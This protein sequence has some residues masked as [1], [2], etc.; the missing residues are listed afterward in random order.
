[1]GIQGSGKSSFFRG[2]FDCPYPKD[3]PYDYICIDYCKELYGKDNARVIEEMNRRLE[4]HIER[5]LPFCYETASLG[6]T[7][8]YKRIK[9][10]GYAIHIQ[11]LFIYPIEKAMDRI[12]RGFERHE[13]HDIAKNLEKLDSDQKI[14]LDKLAWHILNNDIVTIHD[15]SEDVALSALQLA[16]KP[17]AQFESGELVWRA[18]AKEILSPELRSFLKNYKYGRN[19][20]KII[21]FKSENQ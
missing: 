7:K 12:K 8:Q 10:E 5:G 20:G 2:L 1:V 15:N 18:D 14:L 9:R 16:N 4:Y 3:F 19:T 13:R 11:F 21:L 17:V 6:D